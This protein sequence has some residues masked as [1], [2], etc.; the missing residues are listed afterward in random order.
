MQKE[1]QRGKR[2]DM[3]GYHKHI[4][5]LIKFAHDLSDRGLHLFS[6]HGLIGLKQGK[7][8]VI[9]LPAYILL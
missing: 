3:Q 9:I 1:Y 7:I 5:E 2:T 4:S 6:G 8:A